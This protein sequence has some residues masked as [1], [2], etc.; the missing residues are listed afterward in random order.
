MQSLQDNIL[1]KD[2]GVTKTKPI[3]ICHLN[4]YEIRFSADPENI[5]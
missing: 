5:K 2:S 4:C 3:L 1:I